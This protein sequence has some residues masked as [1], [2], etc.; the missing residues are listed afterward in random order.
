MTLEAHLMTH[1]SDCGF[2]WSRLSRAPANLSV[3]ASSAAGQSNESSSN[4]SSL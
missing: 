3:P 1:Q 2:A 4:I